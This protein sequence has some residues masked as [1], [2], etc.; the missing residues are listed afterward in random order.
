MNVDDFPKID[1]LKR[2]LKSLFKLGVIGTVFK[3]ERKSNVYEFSYR[4]GTETEL[5]TNAT[6]IVHDAIKERLSLV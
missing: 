2:G 1:N 5:D 3:R 6:F 4:E